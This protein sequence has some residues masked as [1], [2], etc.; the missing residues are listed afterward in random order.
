[1]LLDYVDSEHCMGESSFAISSRTQDGNPGGTRPNV[2]SNH[3]DDLRE[4]GITPEEYLRLSWS[5]PEG[6][7]PEICQHIGV[8]GTRPEMAYMMASA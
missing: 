8:C 2:G 5:L 3:L 7:R 1:M 6:R 4:L